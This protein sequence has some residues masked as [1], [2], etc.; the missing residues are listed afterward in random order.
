MTKCRSR[1]RSSRLFLISWLFLL[2]SCKLIFPYESEL[3]LHPDF[4]DPRQTYH[5]F[6]AAVRE[7]IPDAELK[8]FSEPFKDRYGLTTE[9]YLLSRPRILAEY[10][11]IQYVGYMKVAS[12][13]NNDDS[14]AFVLA[15]FMTH[16][17]LVRMVRQQY[18]YIILRDG[19]TVDFWLREPVWKNVQAEEDR[20]SIVLQSPFLRRV[21][22]EDIE[23]IQLLP[24]WKIEAFEQVAVPA[25]PKSPQG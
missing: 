16:Q 18:A 7:E 8:C 15:S 10:P 14:H 12:H 17:L 3:A 4:S 25:E 1:W 11:K 9:K 13:G 23:S 5:S 24:E 2:P 21:K 22:R 6:V 20:W 19:T